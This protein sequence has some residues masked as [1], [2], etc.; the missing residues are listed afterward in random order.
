MKVVKVV[1]WQHNLPSGQYSSA[2]VHQALKDALASDGAIDEQKVIA[3]TPGLK[4]EFLDQLEGA[5][6]A[7]S[8]KR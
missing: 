1:W 4:P 6:L 7:A 5:E 3:A 2:R 8:L